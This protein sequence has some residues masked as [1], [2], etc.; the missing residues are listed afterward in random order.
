MTRLRFLPLAAALLAAP[1]A[2]TV[3]PA[4]AQA[5]APAAEDARLKAFLDAEFERELE[6]T[7]M[8]AT[9]IG[10]KDHADRLNDYTEVGL[11]RYLE[12][13]RGSVARL[14]AR[15]NRARLSSEGRTNYDMWAGELER[16]ELSYKYRRQEP[17]L[18]SWLDSPHASLPSFLINTHVVESASD[19]RSYNARLRALGP[20]I[21]HSVARSVAA[22]A[23]NIRMPRFQYERVIVGSRRIVTGAPFDAAPDSPLWADAQAKVRRLQSSGKASAAEGA[24]LLEEARQ[25]L[26]QSVGPAYRRVVAWGEA[27][28]AKAPSG[29]VGAL[30]LPEGRA[31]YAAQLKR[32]TTTALTAGEIHQIGLREVRRI[33]GEQDRLAKTTGFKDRLA[34]YA[35]LDRID[36]PTP[37]TDASRTEILAISNAHVARV[38][39]L[40]PRWFGEIP[41]HPMEVVREPAF[42]EVAGGAAH[43]N[44]PSADGSRPGRVWLHMR[45]D[46]PSRAGLARLMCH[47]AVPGHVMQGDI[48]VRQKGGPTF[49]KMSFRYT[50][51]TEGWGLYAEAL[52]KEMGAYQD[53]AQDFMRLHA[54][55]FRAARLVTDTGIHDQGWTEE[56]AFKYMVETGHLPEQSA[57]SETRRYITNPGQATAYKIGMIRIMEGRARAE[58]ALGPKFDVKAFNDLL[59]GAGSLPLTVMDARI[60]EWVATRK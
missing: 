36:A 19:M 26:L 35:E 33:E 43:A 5:Q 29:K 10:R 22:A 20:A 8:A 46:T 18:Y 25:A 50:A 13:R 44:G 11:L 17:P 54:E 21:D 16:A 1:L 15:F 32:N 58:K 2:L 51:F 56:Q 7:P 27:D 40:M 4:P 59:V 49:R 24:A 52:C 57:R 6:F 55:L 42:S 38:R 9:W 3:L 30:T 37:F 41:A 39:T 60:D 48:G 31:Y 23:E 45:G 12:W 14:K 53:V 47:E 34:Y 28:M